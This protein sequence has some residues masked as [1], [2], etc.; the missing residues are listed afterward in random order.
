MDIDFGRPLAVSP[1]FSV[2]FVG[3][4]EVLL[5][6]EQ[7]S[8][9]LAGKLYVAMMPLLDGQRTGEDIVRT[10]TGRAPEER[11]RQALRNLVEKD[12]ARHV[13]TRAPME[14]QALWV[15]LGLAPADAERNLASRSVAI[16]SAP[17]DG[18]AAE[19]AHALSQACLDAGMP[20][21]PEK[22]AGL[23]IVS[24]DDYLRRDLAALNQRLR[25]E[26]RAWMPFKAGGVEPMIGPLFRPDAAPCWAC[27]THRML[28]N[29]PGDRVVSSEIA[30]VRP[31]RAL[32]PTTLRFAAG[33]AALELAHALAQEGHSELERNIVSLDLRARATRRHMV[34]LDPNC[35]VCGAPADREKALERAKAPVE[36]QSRPLHG[37]TDGGWRTLSAGEAVQRLE[38][39]VSPLTGVISGLED[40]S[41]MPGLPVFKAMQ[42]NPV[43]AGPRE[44]RLIGRP[45]GAAGKG[46]SEV[47]AKASC[48]AEAMERYLCG[49]TGH[50]PALRATW[51]EV[52]DQAPHPYD[53]LNYSERQYDGRE[54]WNKSNDGFNWIGER[55]DESRAIEWTP[56]WSLTRGQ[57]R[58]LPTRYCYF[59]YID[60]A[61]AD[62]KEAN[63]F[64]RADSNG[65]ASGGTLEE[66][67]LQG[68]LELVERDACALWWYNRT[69][70]PAFDLAEFDDPFVRRILAYCKKEGRGLEVLD[71]TN[72]L[73]I[74]V[75][76]ALSHNLADGK[77]IVLGLGAHLDVEI[78]VSRALA[79]M[80][81]MLSLEDG[82]VKPDKADPAK[83]TGDAGV[84]HDWMTN[85]S[86]ASE[87]YCASQG[88]T[89]KN[90]YKR[91]AIGDLKDAV[92][93]CMRAVSDR[94]FEMIVLDHRRPEV[95]FA[96]ARIVVPGLRHFWARFRPGRLYQA[97]VD[98]GWLSRPLDEDLLNP[99]PFFL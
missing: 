94:G 50:E 68:F 77:S 35:P 20:M 59:G 48:L 79:E 76:I 22:D 30:A 15:E 44:N 78:A 2:H 12:Y 60:P 6:S 87:P 42:T 14:R 86:L 75:A 98:M 27:L 13:D 39:Y 72:D 25:Q 93:H 46:M 67:I 62:P 99:I 84:M 95:D 49:Y 28:E 73:G 9:R 34:R 90:R 33:F 65:C 58:W 37:Q 92:D 52:K 81:Q 29:R 23:L 45:S 85:R 18:P 91:P 24:V 82:V 41:P 74:P 54:A 1:H 26:G 21:A 19:A 17:D 7:R 66:A 70:R 36:L 43:Q 38:R 10:F 53:Y 89:P 55:F 3:D 47:Q 4:R 61:V 16:K 56:A 69:P 8:F 96:A 5:L 63:A 11:V 31:A 40:A 57:L 64:C 80:N 97:P 83:L 88:R 71:L 32:T 51:S